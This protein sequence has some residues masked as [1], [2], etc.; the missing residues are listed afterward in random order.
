MN[1][2]IFIFIN[3]YIYFIFCSRHRIKKNSISSITE[4]LITRNYK[5]KVTD[6][7]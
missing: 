4:T 5:R 2:F 3:S 1:K 7:K 6:F